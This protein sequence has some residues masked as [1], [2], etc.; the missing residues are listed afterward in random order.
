MYSPRIMAVISREL[1]SLLTEQMK[2]LPESAADRSRIT[3]EAVPTASLDTN[4]SLPPV[5]E[6]T[7]STG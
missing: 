5:V 3:R 2:V 1:P 4:V 7:V 6:N